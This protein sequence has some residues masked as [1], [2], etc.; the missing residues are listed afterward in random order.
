M[1]KGKNRV[2]LAALRNVYYLGLVMI[3]VSIFF[4]SIERAIATFLYQ[5]YERSTRRWIS[6]LMALSQISYS[7]YIN[8]YVM[9]FSFHNG[10]KLS[11]VFLILF[12]FS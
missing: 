9:K 1:I 11:Y 12:C 7:S 10:I 4:L 5:T 3:V 8:A 2:I 6:I